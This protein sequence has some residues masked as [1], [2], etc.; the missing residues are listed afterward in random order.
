MHF[1]FD[2]E[3]TLLT[4]ANQVSPTDRLLEHDSALESR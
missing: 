4:P 3:V 2:T 1:R